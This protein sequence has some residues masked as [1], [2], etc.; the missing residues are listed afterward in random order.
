MVPCWV[1]VCSACS[2]ATLSNQPAEQHLLLLS[3]SPHVQDYWRLKDALLLLGETPAAPCSPHRSSCGSPCI[4]TSPALTC[5]P[6]SPR[7]PKSPMKAAL[8]AVVDDAR[9]EVAAAATCVV[10]ALE[11][12]VLAKK[13]K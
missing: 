11:E 13:L 1:T 3:F 2:S 7:R 4:H 9:R 8:D 10:E 6:A 12:E 5:S